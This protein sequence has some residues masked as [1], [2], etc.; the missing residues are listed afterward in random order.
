M[1]TLSKHFPC[2]RNPPAANSGRNAALE[3][4][5][6]SAQKLLPLIAL[7]LVGVGL[8][9]AWIR[10]ATLLESALSC[11]ENQWGKESSIQIGEKCSLS[12]PE[13]LAASCGSWVEKQT[14]LNPQIAKN[15]IETAL[16]DPDPEIRSNFSKIVSE[17]RYEYSQFPEIGK[18]Y[19]GNPQ[20]FL[21]QETLHVFLNYY[22]L[23]AENKNLDVDD[24]SA[25]QVVEMGLKDPYYINRLFS[26]GILTHLAHGVG[27]D[28]AIRALMGEFGEWEAYS[29][30]FAADLIDAKVPNAYETLLKRIDEE[31][32][33]DRPNLLL[34]MQ[35]WALSGM[36]TDR[37]VKALQNAPQA[38]HP[39]FRIYSCL[40]NQLAHRNEGDVLARVLDPIL[41][42]VKR[43]LQLPMAKNTSFR[44][45]HDLNEKNLA[46]AMTEA[47]I[48]AGLE[49]QDPYYFST[50]LWLAELLADKQAKETYGTLQKL[51][52]IGLQK[53]ETRDPSLNLLK[54]L[55]PSQG[56]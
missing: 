7:S 25:L 26:L 47:E 16:T 38:D 18:L 24:K 5:A 13:P 39:N 51:A 20:E 41:E 12:A 14:G 46:F 52:E 30:S 9:Y 50:L 35:G 34:F 15:W 45:L 44:T 48:K 3:K 22:S 2:F 55:A 33:R 40:A 28:L 53:P 23:R 31:P 21:N 56:A 10:R 1:I 54:K 36:H 43:G 32:L 17:R 11:M 49:T 29:S 4:Q 37:I 42:I 6:G 8:A 27:H 19:F